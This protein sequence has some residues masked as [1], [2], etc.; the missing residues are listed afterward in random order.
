MTIPSCLT[1]LFQV[2]NLHFVLKKFDQ[3]NMVSKVE[4]CISLYKISLKSKPTFN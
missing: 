1:S 4:V 2:S 3:N